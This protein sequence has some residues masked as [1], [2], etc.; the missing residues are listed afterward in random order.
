MTLSGRRFDRCS[1]DISKINT[2]KICLAHSNYS[3]I[4][5]DSLCKVLQSIQ[6]KYNVFKMR[7]ALS[8]LLTALALSNTTAAIQSTHDLDIGC[9][10]TIIPDLS[11][12]FGGPGC[13]LWA[14]IARARGKS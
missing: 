13:G 11:D 1:S 10:A 5:C 7:T 3:H 12:T 14:K 9:L 8:N 2:S 6:N 4:V